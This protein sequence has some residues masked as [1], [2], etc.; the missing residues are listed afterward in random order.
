MSEIENGTRSEEK[1]NVAATQVEEK[2]GMK[3]LMCS[4]KA[5]VVESIERNPYQAL[6]IAAGIG[7]VAGLILKRR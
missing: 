4:V 2:E 3:E 6:A 7:F 5:C 1:G